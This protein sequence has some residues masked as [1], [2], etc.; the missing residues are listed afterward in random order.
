[1]AWQV[2]RS[3][4]RLPDTTLAPPGRSG[5]ALAGSPPPPFP[6]RHSSSS[7]PVL[8]PSSPQVIL[9]SE[10]GRETGLELAFKLGLILGSGLKTGL[11]IELLWDLV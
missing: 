5:C 8:S 9:C 6:Q 3:C 2:P 4:P 10:E 1:M 11:G 7:S